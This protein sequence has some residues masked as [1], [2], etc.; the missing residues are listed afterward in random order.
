[1]LKMRRR[2]SPIVTGIGTALVLLFTAGPLLLAFAGSVIPDR[3][4]FASDKG[5]F[6]ELT[7]E[8]YRFIFTGE[9][10]PAYLESGANRTMISDAA[11]QAP[12]SLWNSAQIAFA[13]LVINLILGAPAAFIY[14][15][16]TFP[17]KKLSFMFIILAP[18][19][20]TVALITPIYIM[21]QEAGLIGSKIG[22][23]FVHAAK[24]LPFTV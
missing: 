19:V 8:N 5:L 7:L 18:L 15:R 13:A 12:R 17:G 3:V 4:M 6:D 20:P 24:A 22:I 16:Y 2:S 10:P 9:L 11:R 21:I 23:I 14:A 1:M